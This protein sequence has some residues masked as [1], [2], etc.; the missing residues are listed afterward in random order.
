MAT[1]EFDP[2]DTELAAGFTIRHYKDARKYRKRDIIADAIQ[3][4]FKERYLTPVLG[5]KRHG[6]AIMAVSCLMIEALE[7]FSQGWKTT[8]G[9]SKEAFRLFFC[10]AEQFSAFRGYAQEFYKHIRC[11]IL[12]QAETTK[13]W[14]IRRDVSPLFDSENH[15]INAKKFVAALERYLE[16]L[17]D[18][19]R[20]SPWDD[21]LWRNVCKKMDAIAHNCLR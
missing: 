8:E 19:L 14:R 15:T 21:P 13:G 1:G 3:L 17:C 4:R 11:G 6:F 9:K 20:S 5:N 16:G 7:S 18:Q 10:H 12:H 2:E